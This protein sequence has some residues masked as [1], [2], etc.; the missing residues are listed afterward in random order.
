MSVLSINESRV[1][2]FTSLNLYISTEPQKMSPCK[3]CGKMTQA[4]T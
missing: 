4:C 2:P 1:L 3:D